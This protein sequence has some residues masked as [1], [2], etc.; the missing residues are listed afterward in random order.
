MS[1]LFSLSLS[2]QKKKIASLKATVK[3]SSS[4][5]ISVKF[6]LVE[7]SGKVNASSVFLRG[8]TSDTQAPTLNTVQSNMDTPL[9]GKPQLPHSHHPRHSSPSSIKTDREHN[10]VIFGVSES[11]QEMPCYTRNHYNYIETSSVLS[12]LYDDSN[13][14]CSTCDCQRIG[15]YSGN[16][17]RPRPILA[18]LSTTAEVR[19][20]LTH[21]SSLPSSISIEPDQSFEKIV[22]ILLLER[23]K[24]IEAGSDHRSIKISNSCLY[25]NGRLHNK[26]V[27]S[28]Y[29]LA[30]TIGDLLPTLP[31]L[32]NT[33]VSN[34]DDNQSS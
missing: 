10:V 23:R 18:T 28:T 3:T 8:D 15:R 1:A 5:L 21:H 22:K 20:D 9:H 6:R 11:P 33:S 32:Y 30:P 7:L 12:K 27:N 16:S 31:N 4:D 19:Y 14:R 24:L 17:T 25:L 26:V 2:Q 29:S 34:G 13:P